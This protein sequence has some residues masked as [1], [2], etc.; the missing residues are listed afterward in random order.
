MVPSSVADP[1]PFIYLDP[2]LSVPD[3]YPTQMSMTKLTERENLTT[4]ACCLG[5][6]RPTDKENQVKTYSIK[7][8]VLGTLP[9]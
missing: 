5:P 2:F 1:D 3:P 8:I 7:S 9:F 4:Y 6:G